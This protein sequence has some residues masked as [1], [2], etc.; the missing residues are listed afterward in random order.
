MEGDMPS[1]TAATS[2]S[3]AKK[4]KHENNSFFLLCGEGMVERIEQKTT[5]VGNTFNIAQAVSRNER[6]RWSG[7]CVLSEY[8]HS[9]R[10]RPIGF[11]CI[12]CI[13]T[14][15]QNYFWVGEC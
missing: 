5:T 8:I 3:G 10:G 6:S 12:P 9:R 15:E 1:K 4:R 11:Y 14:T 7:A 13:W 2:D